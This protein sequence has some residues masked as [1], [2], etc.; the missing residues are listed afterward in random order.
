MARSDETKLKLLQAAKEILVEQGHVA[1]TVLTIA[2]RAGVNHGL[3]HHYFGS[4]EGLFVALE[5]QKNEELRQV[6]VDMVKSGESKTFLKGFTSDT[7][8]LYLRQELVV[9]SRSMPELLASLQISLREYRKT[10]VEQLQFPSEAHAALAMAAAVGLA[11]HAK[12]DPELPL[13]KTVELLHEW[14][15]SMLKPPGQP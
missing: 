13:E 2:Q 3:I 5:K 7:D 12:A 11:L 10:L 14:V 9:M 4:K 6:V 15:E 8:A 1:A